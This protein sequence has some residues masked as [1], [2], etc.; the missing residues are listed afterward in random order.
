MTFAGTLPVAY[1]ETDVISPGVIREVTEPTSPDPNYSD[2]I[3][4]RKSSQ[5]TNENKSQS[6]EH[7]SSAAKLRSSDSKFESPS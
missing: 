7:L 3:Y 4:L 1:D 6:V 2:K 5:A